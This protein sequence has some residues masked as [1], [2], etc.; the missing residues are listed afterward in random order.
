[1]TE[2]EPLQRMSTSERVAAEVRRRIWSGDYRSGSRLNQDELAAGLG[3]SRIPVRE[4]LIA[5]AHEGAVQMEPHRGAF[6]APIDE[7]IV[8]DHYELFAHLD[9]FAMAKA[10]ERAD[11][12]DRTQLAEEMG[13]VADTDDVAELHRLVVR[14][15]R[16]FHALGGSPRFDAVAAGLRGLVPGNFFAEVPGSAD[17]ARRWMPTIGSALAD[18]DADGATRAYRAMLQEHA[19][20]VVDVLRHRGVLVDD[21]DTAEAQDRT[22]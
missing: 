19:D 1:M 16:R 8:R 18:G 6:I 20:R 17:A 15:R 7:T 2:V 10:I 21:P 12:S 11:P 4:A 9:G 5:L 22:R 3:V 13:R 14:N